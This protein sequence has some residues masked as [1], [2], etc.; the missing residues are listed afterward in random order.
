[1]ERPEKK[2][3]QNKTT[4]TEAKVEWTHRNDDLTVGQLIGLEQGDEH[5][6]HGA[7][8]AVDGVRRRRGGPAAA[9]AAAAGRL[10]TARPDAQTPGLASTRL[11]LLHSIVGFTAFFF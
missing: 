10:R 8:R 3:K 9:A 5:P 7:G 2:K 6:R 11:V 4:K 1:M